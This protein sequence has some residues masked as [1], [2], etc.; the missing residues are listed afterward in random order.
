MASC[1][2]V[3]V[4]YCWCLSFKDV[5]VICETFMILVFQIYLFHFI[6]GKFVFLLLNSANKSI[7][8][9]FQDGLII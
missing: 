5:K 7:E 9:N 8:A 4:C 1:V 6:F 3:C 2:G